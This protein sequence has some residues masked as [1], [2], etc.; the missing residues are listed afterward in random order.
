MAED[1]HDEKPSPA[2]EEGSDSVT[3]TIKKGLHPLVKE[4]IRVLGVKLSFYIDQ[5]MRDDLG[6]PTMHTKRKRA[7]T[8]K[9]PPT[10]PPP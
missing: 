10:A 9:R 5:C 7:R 3:I 1:S 6:L 8:K 4:R 2:K